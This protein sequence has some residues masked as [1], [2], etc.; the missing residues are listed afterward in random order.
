MAHSPS[1]MATTSLDRYVRTHEVVGPPPRAGE[2]L[3]R[4]GSVTAKI[5]AN[6]T[7]TC[8]AWDGTAPSVGENEQEDLDDQQQDEVW[9]ALEEVSESEGE[10]APK[11]KRRQTKS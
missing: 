3:D 2:R 8:I 5:Y 1:A 4:K 9:N 7:P 10:Q 11:Q 6:S